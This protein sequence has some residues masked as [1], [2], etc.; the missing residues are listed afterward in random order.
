MYSD[1]WYKNEAKR[2]HVEYK[3]EIGRLMKWDYCELEHDFL[4]FL[5]EYD[6]V[7]VP[8]DFAII[9][10]GCYMGIQATYFANHQAYIGVD[11]AVPAEWRFQ[12][13]NVVSFEQSIQDF[14]RHTLPTLDLDLNRC[15]AICSYVPDSEAQQM[16][17]DTFPYHRVVYCDEIISEH[18][19]DD[20][21]EDYDR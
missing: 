6:C 2:L 4:G 17:A 10:L 12:Q 13:D 14:L 16:V 15:F 9:D 1:D 7:K 21:L 19:P 5:S 8:E 20:L 3:D 11:V 18:L